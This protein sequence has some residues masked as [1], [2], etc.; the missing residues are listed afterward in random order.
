MIP[1]P[2]LRGR[3]IALE[4]FQDRHLSARYVGWLNDPEIVRFSEQRHKAHSLETC[5]A[6]ASSYVGTHSHFWAI[7]AEEYGHIGNLSAAVDQPNLVADLAILIGQRE[8]WGQGL[9]TSAWT[10]AME[11]LLA[12][13]GMRKVTAGTMATNRGMLSIMRKSGMIEEGRRVAQF[14]QDGAPVDLILMAR[15]ANDAKK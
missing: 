13:G 7:V 9:G 10:V 12:D 14:L 3:R 6:Y 1:S 15:F 11:W 8:C 5:R 4:P 2:L